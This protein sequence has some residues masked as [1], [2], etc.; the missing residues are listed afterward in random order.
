MS[1]DGGKTWTPPQYI[2]FG[3]PYCG[4]MNSVFQLDSGR[5]VL[6][7]GYYSGGNSS[8]GW[9]DLTTS[10]SDD[11]GKSWRPSRSEP[12]LDKIST[13]EGVGVQLKD[14]RLWMLLRTGAGY[15]YEA[16]SPDGDTWTK[17]RPTRFVS[18][19]APAGA[20]RLHDGRIV[21]A[22]NNSL[23]PSHVK[24]RLVL[25][26]AISDDEGQSWHG[27]REIARVDTV[28]GPGLGP[29]YPWLVQAN[30][31]A[32]LVR[33]YIVYGEE[34]EKTRLLRLDPDWLMETSLYDDFSEGLGNWIT[35]RSEGA[36]VV[37][38]T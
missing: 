19:G 6:P 4:C 24:N 21:I 1:A 14:G 2:P 28:R 30:D 15:L 34:G 31:G 37:E 11:G 20:I 38:P 26:A 22:W 12:S 29:T 3:H 36:T 27:Y 13:D 17:A 32:V 7:I 23:K 35:M 33:Y 9:F 16:F 18:P 10:I 8:H 25:T 5:I